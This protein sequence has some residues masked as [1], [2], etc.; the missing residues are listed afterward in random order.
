MTR[1]PFYLI[2]LKGIGYMTLGNVLVIIM[3]MALTMFGSNWFTHI[4][5][6]LL[7]TFI[8]FSLVFTVAWQ[9]GT[10]ERSLVKLGRVEGVQKRRWIPAGIIMF[11]V[12]AAPTIVLLLNKLFFPEEDT[13]FLYRFL[14]G[15]AYP[16][17]L[18]FIPPVE[19][20]TQ[21]WVETS[22]RQFDN[23]SVLFPVLMLVYYALI[24]VFTQLGYWAGV[25]DKI[26][27]DKIMYK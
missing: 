8:F 25:N 26:S 15:S 23:M 9:D 5:S 27:K 14:S 11:V 16:F 1:Q 4:I 24:P 6:M 2:T 13:L 3:T 22:L 18:T 21:A 7:G 10:R 19:T 17:V 20:E 12:G